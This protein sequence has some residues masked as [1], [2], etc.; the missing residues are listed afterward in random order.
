MFNKY[1]RLAPTIMVAFFSES[2]SLIQV[3]NIKGN[4]KA[5][6]G[7]QQL[8]CFAVDSGITNETPLS[9][10]AVVIEADHYLVVRKAMIEGVYEPV[11]EPTDEPPVEP[12]HDLEPAN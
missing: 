12:D 7:G 11:I 6:I 8:E 10:L 5:V 9:E 4:F 2:D 3:A 1:V